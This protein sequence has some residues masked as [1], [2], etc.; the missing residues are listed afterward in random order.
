MSQ[1]TLTV[2]L[3]GVSAEC[4]ACRWTATSRNA[5]AIAAKHHDATS[6]AVRVTKHETLVYGDASAP[7]AG[8]TSL[9]GGEA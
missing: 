8:Q 3:E 1:R 6:H 2:T 5:Q 4:L 7:A 9:I